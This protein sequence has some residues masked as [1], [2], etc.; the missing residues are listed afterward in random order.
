MYDT[1]GQKVGVNEG[2]TCQFAD[3][4]LVDSSPADNLDYALIRLKDA[5]GEDRLDAGA[6]PLS[7]AKR[8]FIEMPQEGPHGLAHGSSLFILQHPR[9]DPLKLA[10][11]SK[12]VLGLYDNGTR[13]RYT[14]NTEAGSSG[15]PC[16]TPNWELVAL[17]HSGDPDFDPEHKPTYN[18]GIPIAVIVSL[19]AQHGLANTLGARE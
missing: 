8:G 16:F 4:W 13:V 5:V 9:G 17:H 7:G 14:T 19:I 10:I 1:A 11:D 12:S 15:S 18:E 6:D 2:R 3:A